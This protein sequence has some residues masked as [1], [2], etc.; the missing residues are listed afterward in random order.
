MVLADYRKIL[1]LCVAVFVQAGQ[2]TL[3]VQEDITAEVKE[4]I[5]QKKRFW[6]KITHEKVFTALFCY[7]SIMFYL[8][9]FISNYKTRIYIK[10]LP[11]ITSITSID[12]NTIENIKH[13]A[14]VDPKSIKYTP[15]LNEAFRVFS[16]FSYILCPQ[17]MIEYLKNGTEEQKQGV[18]SILHH[19]GI[20]LKELHVYKLF[21]LELFLP[22]SLLVVSYKLYKN[23]QEKLNIFISAVFGKFK[24]F[25]SFISYGIHSICGLFIPVLLIIASKGIIA[26]TVGRYFERCADR[27]KHDDKELE[28][29][30][31]INLIKFLKEIKEDFYYQQYKN[32]WANFL[33]GPH[34][35]IE[36]R[37]AAIER[38]INQ[39]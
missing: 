23:H 19:E 10:N 27:I 8:D 25:S 31:Q 9:F 33:F 24:K 11:D 6:N 16:D 4:Q 30:A 36:D 21:V 20:H 38:Q 5:K 13:I 28:K 32:S 26:K 22:F 37:I 35:S 7:R 1:Y 39:Q 29:M 14:Q 34:D 18:Y 12:Q 15:L 2:A 17:T 3:T